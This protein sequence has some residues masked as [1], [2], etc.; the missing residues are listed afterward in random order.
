[1]K[2]TLDRIDKARTELLLAREDMNA[3][4]L[5]HL[6]GE[7]SAVVIV[8]DGLTRL[9]VEADLDKLVAWREE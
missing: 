9:G 8:L 7:L 4:K 5:Y 2:E 3:K 6:A 1:M